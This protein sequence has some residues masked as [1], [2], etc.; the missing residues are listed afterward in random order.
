MFYKEIGTLQDAKRAK[1]IP[2]TVWLF[3][4]DL[5]WLISERKRIGDNDERRAMIVNSGSL[6]A[7]YVNDVTGR[8]AIDSDYEVKQEHIGE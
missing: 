4:Q 5:P 3:K 1:L 8:F 6:Y 7:L 2:L